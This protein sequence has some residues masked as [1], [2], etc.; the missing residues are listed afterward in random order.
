MFRS[1]FSFCRYFVF[2]LIVFFCTRLTFELYFY[3]K[4]TTAS[5]KEILLTFIH[6]LWLDYSAAA[7][8]CIT[9]LLVF[10]VNWFIPKGHIP[11]IWL[12]IYTWFCV[13]VISFLTII[14][15]NIF[16][17]WGTKVNY[18][19]FNTLYNAPSEAVASTGSS[20]IGLSITIG[21]T[22]LVVGV[23]LSLYVVDFKFKKPYE[24]VSFKIPFS[25]LLCFITL[26]IIRGG[27]R[28]AP[29]N[30][31]RAYFS[32]K[33][34]LN[35]A[36]LNTE[37]N[38]MNNVVE[39]MRRPYNA[40]E[41]MPADKAFTLVNDLYAV[42]KDT[43]VKILKTDRPNI[44]IIQLESYTADIIE[45]LGGDKGVSPHFEEFIKDGLLFNN[46]YAAGDRT[47]KGV[48][49]ILSGFPSQ[50]TRT[51]ITD[52]A[53]QKKLPAISSTLKKAGYTTSYFYGGASDYMNFKSYILHHNFDDLS[54][55]SS[56]SKD[57]LLSKWG[58]YDEVT[59]R[60]SVD[61]L[62][63]QKHPFFC[64]IQTLSNH[65][66]FELLGKPK[67]P[68]KDMGNMFRST[69]Y[70]T[71]SCLNAYF[72]QAKKQPWY[73]NTLFVLVADHGHRLPRNTSEA[74]DPRKYHIPLLFFGDV[75][76]DE[77]KGKKISALGGQTDIAATILG[78]LN[79]P[80]ED[81]K[82]SKNLLNPYSKQFAFFD[83]DNG[84]GFIQPEQAVS[85]DNEGDKI[86]YTGNNTAPN[87][88]TENTLRQGQ[89][90][91]QKVFTQYLNY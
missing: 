37:W 65:E 11:A 16:R 35:Q 64:Y 21:V 48:V 43:T 70:Y 27:L 50:A 53:K 81:F 38:L 49:A 79:L 90:Y 84:L 80:S 75:I 34:I 78:Q 82:W 68:G 86:I 20:P 42:K 87:A 23:V 13:L 6:G 8:I 74:Y 31:Q 4:L 52:D 17:E 14:D 10:I 18:R 88:V 25:L 47:D 39:N 40:Y 63:K 77:Y 91:L 2:W 59:L 89:A 60:K 32:N 56:F 19:V 36:V 15:L 61:Y 7:Y 72:E 57:E 3:N 76:K 22:L 44:V 66:P 54:D 1:F 28:G 29:I 67:F 71:D 46:I 83:W 41:F 69:A 26:I 30:E 12:K 33:Q 51:I 9:P 73:K 58:A 5:V 55:E 24:S 62:D 85:Y 45:S